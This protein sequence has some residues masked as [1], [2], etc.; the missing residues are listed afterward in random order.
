[1][2]NSKLLEK[3][4][5]FWIKIANYQNIE[6]NPLPIY[7]GRYIK[8]K[9]RTY[10]NKVSTNFRDINIPEKGIE[11]ESFRVIYT[12]SLLVYKSKYYLEVYLDN[13]AYK[14][15]TSKW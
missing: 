5:T 4:K 8:T 2:D 6:L 3:Y 7:D 13:C 14:I 10:N 1:M 12:N 15:E 11:Y 9:I